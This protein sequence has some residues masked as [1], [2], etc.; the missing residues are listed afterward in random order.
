MRRTLGVILAASCLAVSL[1][2]VR[3]AAA[4]TIRSWDKFK[5]TAG[6]F[7]AVAPLGGGDAAVL[8]KETNLVW[9]RDAGFLGEATWRVANLRCLEVG[10]LATSGGARG[11]FRLPSAGELGSL[12][13]RS[14][15]DPALPPGHPFVGVADEPYWTRD[16]IPSPAGAFVIDL[17]DGLGGAASHTD[18]RH[19]WCVRGPH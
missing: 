19:V 16:L 1:L 15:V 2:V 9:M 7:K 18:T 11:G 3:P 5:P 17:A 8:D 12:I 13:D 6:R 4:G 14:R 10:F